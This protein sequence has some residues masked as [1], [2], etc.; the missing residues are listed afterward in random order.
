MKP[1]VT[2]ILLLCI[3]CNTEH[4]EKPVSTNVKKDL[5]PHLHLPACGM[6]YK[7]FNIIIPGCKDAKT[8]PCNL[9]LEDF[10]ERDSVIR[11]STIETSEGT[12]WVILNE[13]NDTLYNGY[14]EEIFHGKPIVSNDSNNGAMEEWFEYKDFFNDTIR[15]DYNDYIILRK[16]TFGIFPSRVDTLIPSPDGKYIAAL[17][18]QVEAADILDIIDA[19]VLIKT[20]HYKLLKEINPSP[21][22]FTHFKGWNGS[23]FIIESNINLLE[24]NKKKQFNDS[25]KI[26]NLNAVQVY[27]YNMDSGVFAL[28]KGNEIKQ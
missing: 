26:D 22:D 13:T 18:G 2:F 12:S 14:F 21:G 27:S 3:A 10:S 19:P 25:D 1:L 5:M 11:D 7:E 8:A 24:L 28:Y 23:Q 15:K 16:D 9:L 17:V 20:G 6:A 4:K